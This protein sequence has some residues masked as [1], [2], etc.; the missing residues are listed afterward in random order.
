M[1]MKLRGSFAVRGMPSFYGPVDVLEYLLRWPPLRWALASVCLLVYWARRYILRNPY[2]AAKATLMCQ[3]QLCATGDG[4]VPAVVL[5]INKDLQRLCASHCKGLLHSFFRSRHAQRLANKFR[6]YGMHYT[7]RL[8]HP[9]PDEDPRRQGDLI[10]LKPRISPREKGV[11]LVAFTESIS[12]LLSLYN[13]T[14]L[15][16]DYRLVLEP[17]SFGYQDVSFLMLLGLGGDIVVQAPYE[18]DYDYIMHLGSNLHPTRLGAGDWIDADSFVATDKVEKQYD[19]A[20][21][22]SWSKIKRHSLLF[23]AVSRIERSRLQRV[24]LIGYP[25]SGRTAEDIR[26]AAARYGVLDRIHIHENIQHEKVATVLQASRMAVLLSPREG[27]NRGIYEA[28]F[29]DIPIIVSASNKGVNRKHVNS[30]T[31]LLV[32]DA[33]LHEAIESVLEEPFRFS[34]RAWALANTGYRNST[35]QLSDLIEEL[36]KRQ[37]EEWTHGLFFKKNAPGLRYVL[38]EERLRAE[39]S[40]VLLES[41][42]RNEKAH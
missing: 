25:A 18:P 28:L 17:S 9:R 36:A 32:E 23:A 35:V 4:R 29:C 13:V 27:A 7:I 31:G 37:G 2:A 14:G 11:I 38:E 26:R 3:R 39:P 21:V 1:G 42:L 8:K 19:V 16:K 30:S 20:M 40:Y 10:V 12:S 6:G 15:L 5:R 33:K 41:Y 24:A 22:A 34:P